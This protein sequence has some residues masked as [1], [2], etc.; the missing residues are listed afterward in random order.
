[1]RKHN[2]VSLLLCFLTI[3]LTLIGCSTNAQ[4]T[5]ID[6]LPN[7]YEVTD[8]EHFIKVLDKETGVLIYISNNGVSSILLQKP[9]T[10]LENLENKSFHEVAGTSFYRSVDKENGVVIYSH[11]GALSN[12]S[13]DSTAIKVY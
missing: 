11:C 6:R 12:W 13:C 8:T 5:N 7:S 3:S 9:V 4:Q 1:M 2:F 10:S